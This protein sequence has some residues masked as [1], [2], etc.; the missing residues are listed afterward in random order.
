MLEEYIHLLKENDYSLTELAIHIG[1]MLQL[2]TSSVNIDFIKN[3]SKI[4]L[5]A[6]CHFAVDYGSQ[7]VNTYSGKQRMVHLRDVFN[8]P[9]RPFILTTTS[10]GQE[11]LDF[12][13]YCRNIFHWNLPYNPID[14]EQREGR[15]NRYKSHAIRLNLATEFIHS[16]KKGYT[17]S[18][19][20]WNSI[21]QLAEKTY[22]NESGYCEIIPYWH[23]NNDHGFRIE[24]VVPL[25]PFSKDESKY[26]ILLKILSL[27]R[28]TFG[29]PNQEQLIHSFLEGT[30]VEIPEDLKKTI[31]SICLNLAPISQEVN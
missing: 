4:D 15:I 2:Q 13:W 29:Q 9:F 3:K 30:A 12:H 1:D 27:Y 18:V 25:Y 16:S 7:K 20:D 22:A 21:F 10:I 5:K 24:R 31:K 28:L 6:R 11:G 19:D 14:L 8:S 23:I 17:K 26:K